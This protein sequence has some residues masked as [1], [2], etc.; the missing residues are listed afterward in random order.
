MLVRF[1]YAELPRPEFSFVAREPKLYEWAALRR[2]TLLFAEQERFRPAFEWAAL[3][4]PTFLFAA[5]ARPAFEFVPFDVE[6]YAL[7]EIP[8]RRLIGQ[9]A[10]AIGTFGRVTASLRGEAQVSITGQAVAR[11][12]FLGSTPMVMAPEARF[13][14]TM[15]GA[16]SL[17]VGGTAIVRA[18]LAGQSGA[19]LQPNATVRMGLRG[20]ALV[21]LG[22][23]A[24]LT[25]SLRGAATVTI[26]AQGSIEAPMRLSGEAGLSVSTAAV[27]R[28]VMVGQ[29]AISAAAQA[30]IYSRLKGVAAASITAGAVLREG[31]RGSAAIQV[32]GLAEIARVLRGA[33]SITVAP[34]AALDIESP[35][36]DVS[37]T[38][39]N[40]ADDVG[41]YTVGGGPV[42]DIE[43]A[44]GDIYGDGSNLAIMG[45]RFPNVVPAGSD[46]VDASSL[47]LTRRFTNAGTSWGYI[48]AVLTSDAVPWTTTRPGLA[49]KS[50]ARVPI[51][52]GAVQVYDVTALLQ[53]IMP[54]RSPGAALAFV[55]SVE[56]SNGSAAW[57]DYS[58]NA[59]QAAK[60]DITYREG[61]P[62]VTPPVIT[63]SGSITSY[64]GTVLSH[65]LTADE[66]VTWTKVGGADAALFTVSGSTLSRPAQ[67][68][69]SGPFTVI[70]RAT[71]SAENWSEQTIT[72]TIAQK[73]FNYLASS[74][75]TTTPVLPSHQAGDLLV[76]FLFRDGSTTAP[77]LPTGWTSVRTGTG[78]TCS[79]R[80]AYK[81]ATSSS[82]SPGAAT[83]ATSSITSV[84]RPISGFNLSV[85]ASQTGGGSGTTL[86][87]GALT[88]QDTSGRSLVGAFAGHR[89]VNTSLETPPTGMVLRHSVVDATDEAA[90]FDTGA[91]VTAWTSKTVSVGGT[92]SGWATVVYEIK[93]TPA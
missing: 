70:V 85:G 78:T 33:A 10:V 18:Q 29:A 60:L 35:P 31:L 7:M 55:G 83:T 2:P 77:A 93:A 21:D 41:D 91:G 89:S 81:V 5:V 87:Y 79:Y 61:P 52:D 3:R 59:A 88:L 38:I 49:A 62:D 73:P 63:S 82:E 54:L 4:R 44:N 34:T 58:S 12:P 68:Y 74:S 14:A 11:T 26:E 90:A 27:L 69:P 56:G 50:T 75:G 19:L 42:S 51:V 6:L 36:I 80:I 25:L 28:Q 30:K 48:H 64:E 13:E 40:T 92:S 8:G 16:V 43:V 76:C 32:Q 17:L 84:Y 66:S 57:Q 53:E 22:G 65:A 47:T 1:L 37:Y 71:D 15:R 39:T 67:T 72:D 24:G 46:L 23:V 45:L 86:T 9:A 20:S